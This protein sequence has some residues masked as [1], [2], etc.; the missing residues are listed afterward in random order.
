MTVRAF[1]RA[2]LVAVAFLSVSAAACGQVP[3]SGRAPIIEAIAMNETNVA[4]VRVSNSTL[5]GT[6]FIL[7][8]SSDL[9]TPR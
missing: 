2:A 9:S 6:G 5:L 3:F 1:S 8:E 4:D 7:D